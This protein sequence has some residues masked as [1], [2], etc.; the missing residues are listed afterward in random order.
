[1]ER[2]LPLKRDWNVFLLFFVYFFFSLFVFALN[3]IFPV[4]PARC[5]ML[6]GGFAPGD[7]SKKNV[8]LYRGYR[9]NADNKKILFFVTVS[10]KKSTFLF[11]ETEHFFII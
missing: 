3:F 8:I 2:G 10:R 4:P 7:F 6:G 11:A 5:K 1:V 9:F